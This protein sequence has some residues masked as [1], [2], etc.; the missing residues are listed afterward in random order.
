MDKPK[1]PV[2]LASQSPRRTELLKTIIKNFRVVP[3]NID[4]TCNTDL[5]PEENAILLASKKADFVAKLHP[6]HL[7]IGADTLVV[8]KN[9]II[10]KPNNPENARQILRQLSGQ[11]HKVITGLALV[12]LKNFSAASVS[13]VRIKKLTANEIDSYVECGEPMDKAGA[14][15][16]QGKGS[17]LVEGYDG[18]YSNIV[19]LPIELLKNLLQKLN[20]SF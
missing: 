1:T 3:S 20:L 2:I 15:A 10:G 13:H 4:E 9:K 19:G 16:I 6:Q 14:Y 12:H 17:F 11:E 8:L 5:L 18:S 7:I